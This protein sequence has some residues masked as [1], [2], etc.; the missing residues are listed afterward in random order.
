MKKLLIH[1]YL[2]GRPRCNGRDDAQLRA[3]VVDNIVASYV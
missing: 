3:G 1:A 2:A